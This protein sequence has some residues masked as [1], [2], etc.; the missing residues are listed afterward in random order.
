MTT[1]KRTLSVR[2]D[3]AAQKRVS[4]AARLSGLSSSAFL[5]A[6][7]DAHARAVL[8]AWA[9]GQHQAGARSFSEL[10]EETGL[11]IEEL[12]LAASEGSWADGLQMFLA[13]CRAIAEA[14][15][16]PAFF[17]AAETA[18]A[19]VASTPAD[20]SPPLPG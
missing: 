8:K 6:A 14:Q 13:S 12:M 4:L 15:N 17:A 5:G 1:H 16:D 20:P 10:A 3:E 11:A 7:G 18:A 19:L 2:L 9:L